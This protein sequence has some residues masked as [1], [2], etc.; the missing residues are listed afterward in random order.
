MEEGWQIFCSECGTEIGEELKFCPK[1]G[2]RIIRNDEGTIV[3]SM[4]VRSSVPITQS[5]PKIGFGVSV[6]SGVIIFVAAIVYLVTGN[7][8]AGIVGVVFVILSLFFARRGYLAINKKDKTIYG[9]IPMFIGFVIMIACGT[10]LAFNLA[11]LIGGF[12][13][14]VGGILISAGK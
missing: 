5:K 10:L 3:S 8:V 12:L 2:A 1:C 11:V 9:M 14:T 6:F 13:M 4:P 7:P